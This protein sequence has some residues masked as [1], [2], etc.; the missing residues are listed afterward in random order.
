MADIISQQ[1]LYQDGNSIFE[2]VHILGTL[3]V[4]GIVKSETNLT[5]TGS[6]TASKFIGD[7]SELS[8]IDATTIKDSAGTTQIQGTTTGA[9]HSGKAVFDEL[10]IGGKLYDGDGDFGTSGQVLASDGTNTNWVNTGSLTAGAASEVGVTAVNTD[11]DHFIAF[12]DSSSGNENVKVDTN[13]TYNPSSNTFGSTNI[14]T[15]YVTGNL[16]LGGELRDGANAFGTSGQVLSS[17]GTDTAWVNAGS[18]TAGAAAEVGVTA[19]NTTDSTHFPVFVEASSGNEEVRVDTGFSYNPFSGTLT[20]TTFSG[21]FSGGDGVFNDLTVNGELKDGAGNFGS[22]G[23]VLSSDGTDTAWVNAGSLTAGAAAEV[24]VN[25]T[26]TTDSTHFPVFVEASSGNEEVRVDTG[27]TYNPHDGNLTATAFTGAVNL[28]TA[29]GTITN[30]ARLGAGSV[31]AGRLTSDSVISGNIVDNAVTFA[32]LQDVPQSHLI[33]RIAT[34]SGDATHLNMSQVKAMLGTI[35][36]ATNAANVTLSPNNDNTNFHCLFSMSSFQTSAQNASVLFD[37]GSFT[38]NPSDNRLNLSKLQVHQISPT[39]TYDA[40]SANQVLIATGGTPGIDWGPTISVSAGNNTIVQRHS[41]GYI[42]ANYFNTTPNDVSSGV[43]KVC[44]ETG[45]D[46][47]I[48]HGDTSAIQT[49]INA[50]T[51][52]STNTIVKR[53]ASGFIFANY[54]N[55]TANDVSSGVTKVMVETNNDNYI[56]HGTAAA[57]RSFLNVADGANNITNNN[58]LSNGAGYITS[59]EAA[60]RTNLRSFG[61]NTTYTPSSGTQYIHVHVIGAGGGGSSGT[62]LQGEESGDQRA[63]GGAGGGGYCIGHY[64]ITGSFTGSITVGSGGAGGQQHSSQY[65]SGSAGGHSRFQPSGS[66]NGAGQLTANGGGGAPAGQGNG[67][68][69]GAQ[70]QQGIG[71]N[72]HRGQRVKYGFGGEHGSSA[73]GYGGISGHG[74]GNKGKG[75]DGKSSAEQFTGNS[76]SNGFVYIFEFLSN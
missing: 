50:S 72:G 18:L 41:S 3:E 59:S 39:S 55:T 23:Q 34:G 71:F 52:A 74:D 75:A 16:R 29:L 36:N 61:S 20:A 10:E 69:G 62:E 48:R 46:G 57:V 27:F 56:R 2:N 49:F 11:S 6:I 64:N 54:F 25:E 19:T 31:A 8:G 65:R 42:F 30:P 28:S 5:S 68:G 60:G 47:Y 45:N 15:L 13:L 76:G 43:T 4:T 24:G 26:N 51:S 70:A 12:V 53:D 67:S 40:G 21:G 7:G 22:S 73:L 35:T 38:Y 32:K 37:S 1:G 44:V 14:A 17:D 33:G 9:T 63:F 66:Y 58:Q